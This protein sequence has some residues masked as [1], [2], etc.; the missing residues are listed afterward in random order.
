MGITKPPAYEHPGK[1]KRQIAEPKP[2]VAERVEKTAGPIRE[3]RDGRVGGYIPMRK[4][5]PNQGEC[6]VRVRVVAYEPISGELNLYD[7]MIESGIDTN[8]ALL[9][10][11]RNA[12][13]GLDELVKRS[14]RSIS[15]LDYQHGKQFA[16]TN[17]SLSAD[18]ATQLKALFDPFGILTPRALGAK[19]GTAIIVL[20]DKD[21]TND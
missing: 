6:K 13:S 5:T 9:G 8:S 12:R 14:S 15:N 4:E 18:Q 3:K 19:I 16:E 21:R 7:D 10:L 2:Q 1:R 20:A 11:L 17:W